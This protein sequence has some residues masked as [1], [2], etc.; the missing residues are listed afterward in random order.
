MARR[1]KKNFM[2]PKAARRRTRKL[3]SRTSKRSKK[4][5]TY[6]GLTSEEMQA[7]PLYASEENPE[8]ECILNLLSARARR[9]LGR[10]LS[11]ENQNFLDRTRRSSGALR[12]HRG[13][14]IVLPEFVGRTIGIHNGQM[15]INVNIKAEMIGHYL[16]EYAMTRRSVT[17]SGPGVGATK[18]SKHVP[19]K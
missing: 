17:H 4:E 5:F 9:S 6:R 11:V 10:G 7:M 12:T 8:Q 19:L 16:G 1:K 2:T 3:L 18:S 15:F 14:M 13:D